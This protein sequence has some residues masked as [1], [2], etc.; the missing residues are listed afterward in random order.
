MKNK[1]KGNTEV[2]SNYA[3]IFFFVSVYG[4]AQDASATKF[5]FFESWPTHVTPLLIDA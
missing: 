5:F 4:P 2:K 3:Y 1:G